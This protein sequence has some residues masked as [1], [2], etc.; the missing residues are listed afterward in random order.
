MSLAAVDVNE[1][2]RELVE[3]YEAP[4]TSFGTGWSVDETCGQVGVGELALIWARSGCG[5][6]TLF[7]NIVRNTPYVPTLVVSMEMTTRKQL[8]WL[9][10]MS[11]DLSVA[12]R[13]VEM[14]LQEGEEDK[15]YAEIVG[16]GGRMGLMYPNLRFVRPS[17]PSVED[18]HNI[19]NDIED[20]SGVKPRRVFI[21]HLGLMKGCEDYQGYVRTAGALHSWAMG[22]GLAVWA[23]QQTGRGGGGDA[24]RNDGHL[25]VSLSSGVYAGE[26]DADWVF[27]LYR[28]VLNPKFSKPR[29]TYEYDSDWTRLQ[30]EKQSLQHL[31]ILQV[32][33]NRPTGDILSEGIQLWYDPHTRRM[34]ETGL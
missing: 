26:A 28:P 3:F 8:A 4:H 29:L 7:L 32:V 5:K 1:G 11:L 15:R 31:S 24:G 9:M 25:P 2:F 12:S 16:A 22:E 6:S 13:D 14:V 33:K 20:A 17:R 18:L 34:E 23:L 27:G 30:I 21:D 10:S 19:V